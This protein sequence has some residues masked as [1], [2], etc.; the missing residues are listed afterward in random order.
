MKSIQSLLL[1]LAFLFST[2]YTFSQDNEPLDSARGDKNYQEAYQLMDIWLATQQ[3]FDKLPG[4]SLDIVEDQET[5]WSGA[6]GM[7]NEKVETQTAG[8]R[9]S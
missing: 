3:Q 8:R 9:S 7:A 2:C 4:L 1:V 6:Y 5:A